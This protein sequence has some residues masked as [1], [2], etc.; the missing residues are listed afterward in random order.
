MHASMCFPEQPCRHIV[1]DLKFPND[2]RIPNTQARSCMHHTPLRLPGDPPRDAVGEVQVSKIC[3]VSTL[4]CFCQTDNVLFA[5][6][7]LSS[8]NV[9]VK[10][11]CSGARRPLWGRME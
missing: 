3:V 6:K 8:V 2:T 4:R 7:A 9:T 5:Y 11:H 1:I 10:E